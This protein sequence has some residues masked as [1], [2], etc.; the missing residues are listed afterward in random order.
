MRRI[1]FWAPAAIL[2][3]LVL[4]IWGVWTYRLTTANRD[5]ALALEAE[6]QRDFNE[7]AY[8][9]EQIEAH[10]A[11]GLVTGTTRQNMRYMSDV[12]LHARA[13]VNSFTSL[14]LPAELSAATGK[15]LQQVGD[16]ANSLLRNEAAGREMDPKT[17]SELARLRAQSADLSQ[18]L[19]G[20]MDRY[21]EGGVRWNPPLALSW[22]TL[23]R[24]TGMPGKP[25]TGDQAPASMAP[26]GWD[27]LSTTMEEMPSLLYDG[28]FSDHVARRKP[29]MT[30]RPIS[31][32]EAQRRLNAYLPGGG[33]LQVAG[34]QEVNGTLPAYSFSLSPAATDGQRGGA[35]AHTAFASV[36]RNGG[37]LLQYLNSRMI[38]QGTMG[39]DRA[40]DAA[41]RHLNAIGYRNMVPTYGQAQDGIA[42]VVFAYKKDGVI[43]YPDQ[44]KVNV[45]LDNG[46]VVGIDA[47]QYLMNHHERTLAPPKLTAGQAREKLRPE[48]EVQR[49]QL[50]LIPDQ[51]GTGEILTYE[52][53]TT[54]GG[55]TYLVYIN[56]NTGWEEQILQLIET[57]GGTLAL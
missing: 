25:A 51:A 19:Q 45:A 16:F 26:G 6:R 57:D 2:A 33:N 18:K 38:G 46:E 52:F 20:I 49:S 27:Q 43:V 30:G 32:E 36:T 37:Y 34:A 3:A 23:I 24:G 39:L 13:A 1:G 21:N 4:A 8:H 17:Y 9:V 35:A 10:L 40:R 54:M 53:L 41:R 42:T 11:K 28:P 44:I 50:A 22:A 47:R 55:K 7:V 29:A 12:N 15:F 14:P 5:L 31:Q 48:L 56:A